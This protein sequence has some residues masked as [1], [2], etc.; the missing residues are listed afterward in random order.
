MS[1]KKDSAPDD[2]KQVLDNFLQKN[3]GGTHHRVRHRGL[4]DTATSSSLTA[5]TAATAAANSAA[6]EAIASSST[7]S[8]GTASIPMFSS[9]TSGRVDDDGDDNNAN[10]ENP[11]AEIANLRADRKRAREKQRRSDAS[12]QFK[13]LTEILQRVEE[14]ALESEVVS[15]A[16][17]EEEPAK[18]KRKRRPR[19]RGND[20][21]ASKNRVDLIARTVT[22][23][24]EL[25]EA[26]KTLRQRVQD[27]RKALKKEKLQ[28]K[29]E[30][31]GDT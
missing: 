21:S 17:E 15:D 27:L 31:D 11:S 14:Q 28:K 24:N 6:A 2:W 5:A 16:G 18:K 8:F 25:Y 30:K 10:E 1:E 26:N 3:D 13:S 29:N 23:M 4:H 22:V 19:K 7:S 12:S 9:S 20:E